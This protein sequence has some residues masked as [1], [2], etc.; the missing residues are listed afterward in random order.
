MADSSS[1]S[2]RVI[3]KSLKIVDHSGDLCPIAMAFMAIKA[4]ELGWGQGKNLFGYIRF[5]GKFSHVTDTG[6]RQ[7][8]S[9]LRCN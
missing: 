8:S 1:I 6:Q 5:P 4:T 9:L 2:P 7:S 3:H